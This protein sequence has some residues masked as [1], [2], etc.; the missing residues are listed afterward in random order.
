MATTAE[1]GTIDLRT[2]RLLGCPAVIRPEGLGRS[3]WSIGQCSVELI[4][5]PRPKGESAAGS[6]VR[7]DSRAA[8]EKSDWPKIANLASQIL[9]QKLKNSFNKRDQQLRHRDPAAAFPEGELHSPKACRKKQ[10]AQL[11]P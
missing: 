9:G 2:D 3:G 11:H 10:P 6:L 4:I 5:K 8:Q 7:E 1:S